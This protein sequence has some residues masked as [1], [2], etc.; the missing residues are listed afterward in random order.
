M[1]LAS[2]AAIAAA[3]LCFAPAARAQVVTQDMTVDAVAVQPGQIQVTGVPRGQA[4]PTTV[5]IQFAIGSDAAKAAAL[6]QCHRMLLLALSKPGQYLLRQ[7][8]LN[9]CNVALATP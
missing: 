3:L 7:G 1:K 6:E 4:T 9:L 5:T 8:G 2:I